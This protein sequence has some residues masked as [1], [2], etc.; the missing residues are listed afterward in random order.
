M[1]RFKLGVVPHIQ[2]PHQDIC[3]VLYVVFHLT[4]VWIAEKSAPQCASFAALFG[5]FIL[6]QP[7]GG[8]FQRSISVRYTEGNHRFDM[9]QT[10][11]GTVKEDGVAV[12]LSDSNFVG[13]IPAIAAEA[14]VKMDDLEDTYMKRGQGLSRFA[15]A[16]ANGKTCLCDTWSACTNS[17]LIEN[18]V[19]WNL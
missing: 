5:S 2:M 4:F 18:T 16:P 11:H 3:T 14:K 15:G 6:F 13:S 9:R 17:E 12:V 1:L 19:S 10:F 7:A 8:I